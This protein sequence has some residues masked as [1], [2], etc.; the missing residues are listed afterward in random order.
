[1][2]PAAPA[3]DARWLSVP[4]AARRLGLDRSRVYAMVR[5]GEL[6][7]APRPGGRSTH[8]VRQR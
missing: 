3:E 4:E 8:R 7:A 5:S 6:Q 2:A 1:M